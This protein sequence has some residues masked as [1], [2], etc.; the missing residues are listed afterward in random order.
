ML[1][2]CSLYQDRKILSRLVVRFLSCGIDNPSIL[3]CLALFF[4]RNKFFANL[5]FL[6]SLLHD[7]LE[8]VGVSFPILGKK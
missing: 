7:L 8:I 1:Q 2:S 6:G 5:Q 3:N 4:L